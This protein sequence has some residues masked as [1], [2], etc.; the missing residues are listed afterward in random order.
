MITVLLVDDEP[1][2]VDVSR[3]FLEKSGDL[4]VDSAYSAEQAI[5]MIKDRSYDVIVSDYDMPGLDGIELLEM[6]RKIGDFTPFIIFTGKGRE[7][8]VIEAF[9]AGADF[10]LQKGGDPRPQFTELTHKI[11]LAV[12][13]KKTEQTLQITRYSVDKAS[14]LI[15]WLD[16][17][18]RFIYANE[19]AC[20]SLGYQESELLLLT[21]SN[22]DPGFTHE[23]WERFGQRLRTHASMSI[24]TFFT[25]KD[26]SLLPVELSCTYTNFHDREVIFVYARENLRGRDG[27]ALIRSLEERCNM[28][29]SAAPGMLFWVS[30]AGTILFANHAARERARGSSETPPGEGSFLTL[31]PEDARE[32]V[33]AAIATM[34]AEGL[35]GSLEVPLISCGGLPSP[36]M[37]KVTP[38][39]RAGNVAGIQLLEAVRPSGPAV[40]PI[41]RALGA[42]APV[43]LLL[44][45]DTVQ[46]CNE[47]AC[48]LLGR[49]RDEVVGLTLIEFSPPY[50]P[51]GRE[52]HVTL[53]ERLHAIES[54]HLQPFPWVFCK[55]D[56]GLVPL[57]ISAREVLVDGER[58]MLL[59]LT[60]PPAGN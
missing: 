45:A 38:L 33:G 18:G 3:I 2:L 30:G 43:A 44:V 29:A 37:F 47:E 6:I 26:Q 31:V 56:G 50:Q 41:S 28:L 40:S 11:R 22:I 51:D 57:V 8:V 48:R 20:R 15:L 5:E 52:S 34:A 19:M 55:G 21:I 24:E 1:D 14:L 35:A 49:V 9:N 53:I 32:G 36:I 27:E 46:D 16:M 60:L 39:P 54:R 13:R 10:Y 59:M 25:R 12:Q 23:E 42:F 17:R 58:M 7:Q 4:K